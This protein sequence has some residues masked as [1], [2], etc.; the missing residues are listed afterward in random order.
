VNFA[1][2]DFSEVSLKPVTVTPQITEYGQS[3]SDS[4]ESQISEVIWSQ[5]KPMYDYNQ[6]H[7]PMFA[8]DLY[9]FAGD[10]SCNQDISA[11]AYIDLAPFNT[12]ANSDYSW[13]AQQSNSAMIFEVSVACLWADRVNS[14]APDCSE[15]VNVPEVFVLLHKYNYSLSK[16]NAQSAKKDFSGCKRRLFHISTSKDSESLF[17]SSRFCIATQNKIL[18]NL[19][20]IEQ[21]IPVTPA[22]DRLTP[23]GAALVKF[24]LRNTST[25]DLLQ[26]QPITSYSKCAVLITTTQKTIG[27]DNEQSIL[28]FG[29]D[30]VQ[31]VQTQLYVQKFWGSFVSLIQNSSILLLLVED[32]RQPEKSLRW[33]YFD[34]KFDEHHSFLVN[35]QDI[36]ISSW[37]SVAVLAANITAVYWDDNE[38]RVGFYHLSWD[39]DNL[40]LHNHIPGNQ[41]S[42]ST[43]VSLGDEWENMSVWQEY[44]R[45]VVSDET[46]N[47]LVVLVEKAYSEEEQPKLMIF[48]RLEC[49]YAAEIWQ[50][51][52]NCYSTGYL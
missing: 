26:E 25:L 38:L 1:V 17:S 29:A 51:A 48:L 8:I 44:S 14:I 18:L 6:I 20:E 30:G 15:F 42:S 11:L 19:H 21:H 7:E 34:Q 47:I 41:S 40:V 10:K 43:S 33:Q 2:I 9:D 16:A 36:P 45:V 32:I 22:A 23:R 28:C 27:F 5:S 31:T 49:V 39:S 4:A 35:T 3:I 52:Q 46:N 12:L 37:L 50:S 13:V 24:E